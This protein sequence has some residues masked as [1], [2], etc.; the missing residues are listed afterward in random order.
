MMRNCFLLFV[1]TVSFVNT[2]SPNDFCI[3]PESHQKEVMCKQ[4]QCEREFC[5]TDRSKCKT[6]IGWSIVL[7]KNLSSIQQTKELYTYFVLNI[8]ECTKTQY[9]SVKSDV[10]QK[11]KICYEKKRWTSRLMFKGVDVKVKKQ[12]PCKGKQK[13]DCGNGYCASSEK[14]CQIIFESNIHE[15]DINACF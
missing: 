7:D 4:H 13:H 11:I 12:C 9:I 15:K 8:K 1:F 10:C 2:F 14:I 5:S 6:F 3:L